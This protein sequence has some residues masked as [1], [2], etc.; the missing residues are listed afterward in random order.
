M[1]GMSLCYTPST[2]MG[3]PISRCQRALGQG[4]GADMKPFGDEP[5]GKVEPNNNMILRRTHT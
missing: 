1:P 5:M 3:A 2:K 4:L